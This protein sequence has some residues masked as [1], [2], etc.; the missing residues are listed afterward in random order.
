MA[1]RR[2]LSER[3]PHW[4]RRVL[5][6]RES[7]AQPMVWGSSAWTAQPGVRPSLI[8][9]GLLCVVAIAAPVLAPDDPTRLLDPTT[10]RS[11]MPSWRHPMGTDPL[12]RDIMSRMIFGV[13]TSLL[14]AVS[15]VAIATALGVLIG[16]LSAYAGGAVD[17]VVLRLT[18]VALS[19]PR[20]VVLL[21]FAA[22]WGPTN[23]AALAIV[24]GVTGWMGVSR[25]VRGEVLR[26][27]HA[28]HIVA[29]RALGVSWRRL[30]WRHVLPPTVP[31]VV[32]SASAGIGQILLL[33]AG[34]SFLGIGLPVDVLSWGAVLLDVS[35]VI[36][37]SRWL[38]IGPGL[39]LMTTVAS[40]YR[41]GEALE[42]VGGGRVTREGDGRY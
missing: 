26:T 39:L 37:R 18:D 12:S 38:V 21:L 2:R 34:L 33:E 32:L 25:L 15:A 16:S 17:R 30:W 3:A 41:I 35:D 27:L 22:F 10:L 8:I 4:A 19:L 20:L 1:R 31:L 11:A 36:G 14:L 13:R 9:L 42:S 29:A 40:F 23:V 28:D 24:L 7:V 5:T 6:P